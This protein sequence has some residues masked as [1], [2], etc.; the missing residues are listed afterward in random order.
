MGNKTIIG[1]GLYGISRH[2]PYLTWISAKWVGKGST[3]DFQERNS[4]SQSAPLALGEMNV[5]LKRRREISQSTFPLGNKRKRGMSG[6][7]KGWKKEILRTRGRA[8][9]AKAGKNPI[10]QQLSLGLNPHRDWR[11]K[12]R[13]WEGMRA[14]RT[15]EQSFVLENNSVTQ[16]A[17]EDGIHQRWKCH[18]TDRDVILSSAPEAAAASARM[19]QHRE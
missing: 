15:R 18:S 12:K 3:M 19:S 5:S 14:R 13:E 2:C 1:P 8:N 9:Q 4:R 7:G 16:T 10:K 6:F 11:E 17:A